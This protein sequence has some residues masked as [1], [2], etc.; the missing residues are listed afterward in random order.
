[1][2]TITIRT[3]I[4][5]PLFTL[6]CACE[7]QPAPEIVFYNGTVITM[8]ENS[9]AAST[10]PDALLIREGVI[11]Q[12]GGK[13][14]VLAAAG[15]D[16]QQVDL[17]GATVLPGFIA[18]HTHPELSAYLHTLVDLSGFKHDS[19]EAVWAELQQA[20]AKT[21]PGDWIFCKGFDP[22]L[23]HG[24]ETPHITQLDEIAPHNPVV[25]LSQSMHSAWANSA[26]FE[27][28]GIDADTPGPAPGSHYEVDDNGKLTG[29]IVEV[30]AMQP[31][32]QKALDTF[33]IKDNFKQVLRGY[34]QNGIT[35]IGTAG[36][37]GNDDKPLMLMRWFS[38]EDP[39]LLL[40]M[41][42]MFGA[43]PERETTVR[44]FVYL[45]AESPFEIPDK[46]ERD[47]PGFQL[48]GIKIWYD[49]SPYTGSMYLSEPY[50][51]SNLMQN[52]LGLPADNRGGAV[53]SRD[54]FREQ[55][56]TFHDRGWQLAIHTQGDQATREV[57]ADMIPVLEQNP[58]SDHRHRL[59]HCL[60]VPPDIMQTIQVNG[61]TLSFH[62]NHLYYY[63]P[64]LENDI[65]GPDRAGRMLPLASAVEQHVRFTLHA[66]QP[67]YPEEPL[68][69]MATA[70][71]RKTREGRTIG[72]DQSI[73][74]FQALR[75]VTIEAAWQLGM[76]DKIGSIEAGKLADLVIL[77]QNPLDVEP[78]DLRTIR[79]LSTYIGGRK[80]E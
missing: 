10:R 39:G 55:L 27:A 29:F 26:A 62:I 38:A 44:N 7:N 18:A 71:Q 79:V 32:M 23:V 69:L 16:A 13:R 11:V 45:K 20:V 14:Q 42:A 31:F 9:D 78:N 24:L 52:G 19:P 8:A 53:L 74:A 67:M 77:N 61:L 60:L 51:Q 28:V 35:S 37:F 34:T 22:I 58:R 40:R 3:F 2:Q 50:L 72:S 21:E 46:P 57:L 76:E 43:L 65:I 68:S 1:M 64:A 12:V 41:L 36:V 73:S 25:I 63:G 33:D 59:E 30:A 15:P 47:D 4:I 5:I 6:L 48:I 17:A 66:D 75:A 56:K 80:V 70:V 54:V 49:G